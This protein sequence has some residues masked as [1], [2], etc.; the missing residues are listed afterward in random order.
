MADINRANVNW[1]HPKGNDPWA[2]AM[3]YLY[4]GFQQINE[5]KLEGMGHVNGFDET[6]LTTLLNKNGFSDCK[7]VS[8]ERNP[9]PARGAVLKMIAIKK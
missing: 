4:G 7:R 3:D 8:D 5:Y 1:L 9:E 2:N 6:S